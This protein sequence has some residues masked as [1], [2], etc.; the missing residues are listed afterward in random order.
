MMLYKD[1]DIYNTG[2]IA[3][4]GFLVLGLG[5]SMQ[6]LKQFPGVEAIFCND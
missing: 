2:D 1:S 5:K 6:V 3:S 4:S